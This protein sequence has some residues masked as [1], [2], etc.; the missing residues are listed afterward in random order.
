MESGD[1]E[2]VNAHVYGSGRRS[3]SGEG[4]DVV[5]EKKEGQMDRSSSSLNKLLCM[6]HTHGRDECRSIRMKDQRSEEK[7]TMQDI[8]GAPPIRQ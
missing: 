3:E 2:V 5:G 6:V 8:V 7:K 1:G 4:M